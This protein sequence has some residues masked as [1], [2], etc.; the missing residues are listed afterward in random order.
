MVV[1]ANHRGSMRGKPDCNWSTLGLCARCRMKPQAFSHVFSNNPPISLIGVIRF[2]WILPIV[3][4]MPGGMAP[5]VDE[6]D[7]GIE[8]L[9]SHLTSCIRSRSQLST[10]IYAPSHAMIKGA[11][12]SVT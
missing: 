6:E 1:C 2:V 12:E 5:C 4:V 3:Q 8:D 10:L 9:G 7:Q 11:T